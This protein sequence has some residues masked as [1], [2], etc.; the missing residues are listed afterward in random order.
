MKAWV[1]AFDTFHFH[2]PFPSDAS[3]IELLFRPHLGH[4]SCPW[5]IYYFHSTKI[6]GSFKQNTYKPYSL[7]ANWKPGSWIWIPDA[8]SIIYAILS[9]ITSMCMSQFPPVK[10]N[11][12]NNMDWNVIILTCLEQFLTYNSLL[13]L[14]LSFSHLLHDLATKLGQRAIRNA[15]A[16]ILPLLYGLHVETHGCPNSKPQII[17][18]SWKVITHII[19]WLWWN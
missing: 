5:W 12:D 14:I 8:L 6:W 1:A 9:T 11:G 15:D 13:A 16:K 10:K 17:I 4:F 2:I 3:S 19:T 18:D 7:C